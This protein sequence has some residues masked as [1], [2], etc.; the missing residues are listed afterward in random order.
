[1]TWKDSSGEPAPCKH[2]LQT[3]TDRSLGGFVQLMY[4]LKVSCLRA[5]RRQIECSWHCCGD[6][7]ME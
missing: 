7:A 2:I 4:P 1:M 5:I 6:K 3:Q